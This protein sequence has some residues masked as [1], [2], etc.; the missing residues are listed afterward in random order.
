M[1]SPPL[2]LRRVTL[3]MAA[4]VRRFPPQE[5][6]ARALALPPHSTALPALNLFRLA[7]P[8]SDI[9]APYSTP[10]APPGSTPPSPGFSRR[11]GKRNLPTSPLPGRSRESRLNQEGAGCGAHARARTHAHT[12]AVAGWAAGSRPGSPR[13]APRHRLAHSAG[14]AA[15]AAAVELERYV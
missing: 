3:R 5:G 11:E 1:P 9:S 7:Q 12:H 13:A 8:V 15:V 4:T 10:S 2:R 6:S 14:W